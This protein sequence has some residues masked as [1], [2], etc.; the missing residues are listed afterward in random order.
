M[1]SAFESKIKLVFWGRRVWK[2]AGAVWIE[3]GTTLSA[4]RIW[5]VSK[6]TPF[7]TGIPGYSGRFRPKLVAWLDVTLSKPAKYSLLLAY[8]LT[9]FAAISSIA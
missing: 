7:R 6:S 3:S 8:F 9:N 1:N 4:L 5:S 2:K